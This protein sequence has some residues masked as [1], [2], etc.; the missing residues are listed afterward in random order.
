MNAA[1]LHDQSAS[2]PTETCKRR[3]SLFQ[4]AS[5]VRSSLLGGGYPSLLLPIAFG[6]R[7]PLIDPFPDDI[8]DG[9]ST[10]SCLTFDGLFPGHSDVSK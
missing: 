9:C 2:N 5:F 4:I 3:V 6:L 1:L 8:G 10:K 7:Y